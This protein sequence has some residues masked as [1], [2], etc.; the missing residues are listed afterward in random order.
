MPADLHPCCETCLDVDHAELA[1]TP[2][3]AFQYCRCLFV[4]EFQRGVDTFM[5]LRVEGGRVPPE[6]GTDQDSEDSV[7]T[8]QIILERGQDGSHKSDGSAPSIL[9]L[10]LL[11]PCWETS[12]Q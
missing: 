9:G 10:I 2:Q 4:E 5:A 6:D 3:A 11:S 12:C 8:S 7:V 1:L